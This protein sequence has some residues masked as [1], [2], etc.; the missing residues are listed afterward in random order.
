MTPTRGRGQ[1]LL[2]VAVLVVV[3]GGGF[4][5]QRGVGVRAPGEASAG[6]SSSGAWFCPHG[7]GPEAWKA[8]VFL[9]NPGDAPVSVRVTSI[10]AK[11]PGQPAAVTVPPQAT[12][13]VPVPATGREASTYVE[14]FD[15][16]VAASWVTQGGGG[17]IGVGAEP[18]APATAPTWFAPDGT[19]EQGEDAY[20]IVMNPFAVDAVFDV[21]LLTPKRAPIRSS[22]LTDHVLRPGKSVAF[23]LN[24]FAEGD[25]AVGAQVDVSLGRVAV[26]SLGITRD[27]GIRGV[28]GTAQTGTQA[29]LPVGGGAGQSTMDLMVPGEG[30]VDFGATLLSGDVPLPAGGLTEASQNPT[31]ARPY[32]VTFSGPSSVDG[33][34]QG[35]GSFAATLRSVGA[36]NDDGA[37]GGAPEPA[38]GWVVLPAIA[39]EPARPRIVIVNPGNTSVTVTLHALASEG[40][41]PTADATMTIPAGSVGQVPPLFLEGLHRSAVEIRSSGGDILA[42]AASTSLG[43]KG[44]STYALA[45]GVAIPNP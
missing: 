27:G 28:I 18:C 1:G 21:V 6:T 13:S 45:M 22:A 10:S 37:T 11:K 19:T 30:Q 4:A 25:P 44:L 34:A 20:L 43:V 16:W 2:A 31:S 38:S 3:L 36:G 7:G 15:G 39:G 26:S 9:A 14:Y 35:E 41:A 24:A 33:V 32:P 17:E 40:D 29:Y 42:L 12:V 5:L 23:R 8:T